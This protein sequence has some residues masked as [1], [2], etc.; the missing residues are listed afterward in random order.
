MS[1]HS[2]AELMTRPKIKKGDMVET[3]DGRTKAVVTRKVVGFEFGARG[4]IVKVLYIVNGNVPTQSTTPTIWHGWKQDEARRK[5][6]APKKR[7]AYL[8][9]PAVAPVAED[10]PSAGV[11]TRDVLLVPVQRFCANTRCRRVFK[12]RVVTVHYCPKCA[13][14]LAPSAKGIKATKEQSSQ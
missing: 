4:G 10:P 6:T 9:F 14:D 8:A 11:E 7:P 12:T 5:G 3:I 1:A 13:P 2:E